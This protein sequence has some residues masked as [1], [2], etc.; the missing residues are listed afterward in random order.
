VQK[1]VNFFAHVA[2]LLVHIIVLFSGRQCC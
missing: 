2:R 1:I